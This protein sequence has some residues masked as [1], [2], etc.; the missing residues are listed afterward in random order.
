MNH[1]NGHNG[2]S[3]R[4]EGPADPQRD[5]ENG[6][7]L[8]GHS[9]H[10]DGDP[11]GR[12]TNGSAPSED[13]K[14]TSRRNL[15]EISHLFLSD[16]RQLSGEGRTPPRR[17]PPAANAGQPPRQDP[18]QREST[19]DLSPEEYG[20]RPGDAESDMSFP[21]VT[22]VIGA[23]L[24]GTLIRRACQYASGLAGE[25]P[26][27][28]MVV[29]A[30]EIRLIW[31]SQTEPGEAPEAPQAMSDTLK[32]REALL[33]MSCDIGRWL[34]VLP[35][36]RLIQARRLLAGLRDWVLLAPAEHDGVVASYRV[37]KSLCDLEL[38]DDEADA[39]SVTLA[40]VDAADAGEAQ[41][42]ARKLMGVCKQFLDLEINAAD[43]ANAAEGPAAG[44]VSRV[45]G[46]TAREVV[47]ASWPDARQ[48]EA[49]WPVLEEVILSNRRGPRDSNRSTE[50]VQGNQMSI[51]DDSTS[52][53]HDNEPLI[54]D[55]LIPPMAR[56]ARASDTW[57]GAL[58]DLERLE[59]RLE[60]R[61]AER[62]RQ[63]L[64]SHHE[65]V[66]RRRVD[67]IDIPE[68]ARPVRAGVDLRIPDLAPAASVGPRIAQQAPAA[69]LDQP[70]S[71]ERAPLILGPRASV[72]DE[73]IDLP[74][75]ETVAD[76]VLSRLDLVLTPVA[77]PM[78]TEARLCVSRTGA[79]VL[80]AAASPGLTD[81]PTIG[82][83]MAWA[84]ENRPLL[85]MALAQYRLDESA[86]VSLHLL[87]S[88][89]DANADALRPLLSTGR[90]TAQA[91]RRLTWGG[92]SGLLLEAA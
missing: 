49:A 32:L 81:L 13:T 70:K 2:H 16:L 19:V 54:P 17:V 84:A 51:F 74:I 3:G 48:S 52:G 41:R 40:L 90:V 10:S 6:K 75:G 9:H 91:Y 26:V 44:P 78:L 30:T 47:C 63:A 39:P 31:V 82:R 92:K 88:R 27:G 11:G 89:A 69:Q 67:D 21:P 83:A 43:L 24:N 59:R 45:N 35:D 76:V 23:K 71:T 62:R 4:F 42:H 20:A 18:R 29:E 64:Q 60:P 33:E 34:V 77:P 79:V 1:S 50:A 72:D 58:P 65:P 36:P 87:V 80:V 53:G 66:S 61:P 57:M 7:P 25:L 22:A 5:S 85:R 56:P 68:L 8:N 28:V 38:P 37:L 46:F 55:H 14:S 12:K 86:E 73:V 15:S